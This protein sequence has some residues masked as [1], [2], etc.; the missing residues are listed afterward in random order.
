M[1]FIVAFAVVTNSLILKQNLI[2]A[3]AG[4]VSGSR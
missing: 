1:G 3:L 2:L 4:L